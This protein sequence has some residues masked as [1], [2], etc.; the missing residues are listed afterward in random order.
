MPV[1]QQALTQMRTNK[2]GTTR[3]HHSLA[4]NLLLLN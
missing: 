1:D 4:H 3:N 2:P